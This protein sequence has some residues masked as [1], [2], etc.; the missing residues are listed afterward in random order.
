LENDRNDW[1]LFLCT[2]FEDNYPMKKPDFDFVK[3]T[4]TW[5]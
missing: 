5:I 4:F 1:I 2:K 3:Q